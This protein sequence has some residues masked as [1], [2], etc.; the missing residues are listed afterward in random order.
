MSQIILALALWGPPI[1]L[2]ITL[3]EVARGY[4]ARH[5]GDET[6]SESGRLSLNPL[7]HVHAVGTLLVPGVIVVLGASSGALLPLFGWAKPIPVD[8]SRL[9][10]PKRDLFWV[11]A[12]GPASS[13]FQA[14]HWSIATRLMQEAGM[15]ESWWFVMAKVG[16]DLNLFLMLIGLV[17]VPPL[18]GGRML[19]SLLPQRQAL[20]LSRVEPYGFLIVIVLLY[21]GVVSRVIGPLIPAMKE[22]LHLLTGA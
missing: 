9:R 1:V 16:V 21:L 10:N 13:F 3:N 11:A 20:L 4:V 15:V 5:F 22:I 19:L 8:I 14:L 2:A 18:D 17:P 12:A 6:G 7:K